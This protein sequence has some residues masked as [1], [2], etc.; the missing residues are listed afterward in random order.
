MSWSHSMPI[1]SDKDCLLRQLGEP[2]YFIN[3]T[4]VVSPRKTEKWHDVKCHT[5]CSSHSYSAACQLKDI[6]VNEGGS[7]NL[8]CGTSNSQTKWTRSVNNTSVIV[9]EYANGLTMPSLVFDSVKWSD[10]GSYECSFTNTAG[11]LENRI[12]RLFVNTSTTKMCPCRCDYRRNLEYWES[13]LPRHQTLEELRKELEPVIRKMENQFKVNKTKLSSTIR[14]L[15]SAKDER[16]SSHTIGFFGALFVSVIFGT[17]FFMDL[18]MFRQHIDNIRKI[19]GYKKKNRRP[20]VSRKR[21]HE[22]YNL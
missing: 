1:L 17:V 22:Q 3:E 10:Q 12:T 5:T 7:V 8:T 6:I 13:K 2:Q 20:N 16:K 4:C 9:S 19:C 11:F 21:N 14:K 18:V 15:T